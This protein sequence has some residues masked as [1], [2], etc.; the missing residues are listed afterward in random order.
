MMLQ[1]ERKWQCFRNDVS[2]YGPQQRQRP[3]GLRSNRAM[4]VLVYECENLMCRTG[5]G[6]IA[7]LWTWHQAQAQSWPSR[8]YPADDSNPPCTRRLG[9]RSLFLIS[10]SSPSLSNLDSET[11]EAQKRD[12]MQSSLRMCPSVGRDIA[13]LWIWKKSPMPQTNWSSTESSK[14]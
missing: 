13:N 5:F 6:K 11:M 3:R 4:N 2:V 8:L 7:T 14:T 9:N 10:S 12:K 1:R